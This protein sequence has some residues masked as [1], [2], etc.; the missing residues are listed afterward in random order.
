MHTNNSSYKFS[1]D[2][3]LLLDLTTPEIS[4]DIH[5]RIAKRLATV[6]LDDLFQ[7]ARS[8]RVHLLFGKTIKELFSEQ[9]PEPFLQKLNREVLIASI[10]NMVFVNEILN[11][12]DILKTSGIRAIPFKGAPLAQQA[13]GDITLRLFGDIDLLVDQNNIDQLKDIFTNLGYTISPNLPADLLKQYLKTQAYICLSR[14]KDGIVI[15]L[16]CDLTNKYNLIPFTLANISNNAFSQK[17][18]ETPITL[19]AYED[20]LINLCIHSSSHSWIFLEYITSIAHLIQRN[21]INWDRVMATA[22]QLKAV[23]MVLSGLFLSNELYN[24]HVPEWILL[25]AKNDKEIVKL[26]KNIFTSLDT[27]VSNSS[28]IPQKFNTFHLRIRDSFSDRLQYL[29]R[30]FFRATI[31]EWQRYPNLACHTFLHPFVRPFRLAID[32][33]SQHSK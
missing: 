29:Y 31:K 16:Q 20:T 15:D 12:I 30:L 18:S 27:P 28:H 22:K 5:D 11:I 14:K 21:P 19:L 13:Y 3:R 25:K 2:F 9:S 4:Q 17:L 6:N 8:H 26:T 24:V 7:L 10:R 23:K 1:D 33:F 32:Y